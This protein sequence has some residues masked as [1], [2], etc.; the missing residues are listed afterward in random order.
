M[1]YW[2][3]DE[4]ASIKVFDQTDN[5][6]D[7]VIFGSTWTSDKAPV[8]NSAFTDINGNY[9][10]DG[11][12]YG[13]GTTF[14]VTPSKETPVGRSLEFDGDDVVDV[15]NSPTL[16]LTEGTIEAWVKPTWSPGSN[17]YDPTILAMSDSGGNRYGIRIADDYAS[18]GVSRRAL[19]LAAIAP[20]A[21]WIEW[22]NDRPE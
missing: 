22:W 10:L 17:G 18:V 7:G 1:A 20:A 8:K 14:T 3:L 15:P 9:I 13:S 21:R 19:R 12:F 2:K 4:G 16:E 6:N 5:S 11:V